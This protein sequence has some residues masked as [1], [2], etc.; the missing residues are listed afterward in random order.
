[1]PGASLYTRLTLT[2]AGLAMHVDTAFDV[3]EQ[4]HPGAAASYTQKRL[5]L[6]GRRTAHLNSHM[7]TDD[8]V[9]PCRQGDDGSH[10]AERVLV[11]AS[12][13]RARGHLA[14]GRVLAAHLHVP[15]VPHDAART[16]R[17]FK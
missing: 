2:G 10:P 6:T 5:T 7:D 11:R 16:A 13:G 15:R 12:A 1:M 9:R 4:G 17:V 14:R 3:F 8:S